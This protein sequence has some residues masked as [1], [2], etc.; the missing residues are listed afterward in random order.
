MIK[1]Q[2]L[3]TDIFRLSSK[4]KSPT[5]E[6]RPDTD[7]RSVRGHKQGGSGGQRSEGHVSGGSGGYHSGG[8]GGH[9]SS[10]R[11]AREI[12]HCLMLIHF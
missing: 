1:L 7:T 8:S 10:S 4:S 3:S 6:D 11:P 12:N 5:T 2:I 9:H